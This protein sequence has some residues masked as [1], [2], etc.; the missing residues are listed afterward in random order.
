MK[1]LNLSENKLTSLDYVDDIPCLIRLNVRHNEITGLGRLLYPYLREL[2]I[3][4]NQLKS[5]KEL[6]NLPSLVDLKFN[7]NKITDIPNFTF[8]NLRA[9]RVGKNPLRDLES[10]T[11]LTNLKIL[12]LGNIVIE[13]FQNLNFIKDLG[14][15]RGLYLFLNGIKEIESFQIRGLRASFKIEMYNL[16]LKESFDLLFGDNEKLTIYCRLGAGSK[17]CLFS[18]LLIEPHNEMY[19]WK[20]K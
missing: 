6:N 13:S 1:E 12:H 16:K 20:Y 3:S 14:N 15:L 10:L 4:W 2:D 5:L 18:G 8:P 11:N 17:F 19:Y 7:S 9:L